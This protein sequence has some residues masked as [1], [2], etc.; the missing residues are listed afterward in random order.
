MLK[1][2]MAILHVAPDR[3]LAQRLAAVPGVYYAG[4]DLTAEFGPLRIDVTD[5]EFEDGSFDAVVCNHVLEHVP[6]DRGAMRELRRVLRPGGW[7]LLQVPL[8]PNKAG[9]V[10]DPSVSDPQ[11]MLRRFGQEDHVRIYGLDYADRLREAG[12]SVQLLDPVEQFGA[13]AVQQ[14]RLRKAGFCEPI[15]LAT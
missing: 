9:T 14:C 3:V 5:L 6:D 2:G 7:A 12:F 1:P 8:D 11:E 4:G 10:E 13:A 15:V